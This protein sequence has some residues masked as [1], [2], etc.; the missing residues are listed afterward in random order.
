LDYPYTDLDSLS[1][2][3]PFG[4]NLE[5]GPPPCDI[6][7]TF[8]R[9]ATGYSFRDGIFNYW[10]RFEYT[11]RIIPVERYTEY[12]S[13]LKAVVQHDQTKFVFKK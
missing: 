4:Y 8:S 7:T 10:R 1:I 5:N 2:R 9:Y 3:L 11:G 13:F 6:Q 12:V